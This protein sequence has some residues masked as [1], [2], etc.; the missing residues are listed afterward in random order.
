MTGAKHGRHTF[1]VVDEPEHIGKG[2]CVTL[3]EV[4]LPTARLGQVVNV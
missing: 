2:V 1:I 3:D 4:E